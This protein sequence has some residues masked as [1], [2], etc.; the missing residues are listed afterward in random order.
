MKR[1]SR[2]IAVSLTILV[3][4]GVLVVAQRPGV[5]ERGPRG[6]RLA[7]SA[8]GGQSLREL[9][10]RVE[11]MTRVRELRLRAVQ[12]DPVLPG[13]QHERL[14]QYYKGVKVFGGE[15]IRETDGQVTRSMTTSLY[16]GIQLDTNPRLS[17]AD[18]VR[19]FRRETGATDVGALRPELMI[20]P[21]RDGT[22]ALVYRVTAFVETELPVV[23]VN[24][25]NGAVEL[26]YNNLRTQQAT[27]LAGNGVLV[28]QNIGVATDQKKVSVTL[29]GSTYQAWDQM[30]PVPIKT[31]DL[32]GNLTRTKDL[33]AGRT[34]FVAAD[35]AANTSTTG[36]LDP[37]VV[38]GH[39]YM[40][41]TYDYYAKR[42]GWKGYDGGNFR[43]VMAIVHPAYRADFTKYGSS[44]QSI[45][46]MNAFFCGS[47]G[48]NREDIM[49]FG[50]GLPTGYYTVPDGQYL[51]YW[52]A[53]LDVVAH[54]YTHGV[55]SYTS[56]LI[57]LNESGAL[58]EAFSDVMS[59]SVR[60]YLRPAGSGLLYADY[61]QG[62]D[63]ARAS[64]P[65][66]QNGIRNLAD[67]GALGD[68]DH[69][70][71]RYT[72]TADNGGVHTNST[73]AGHAFY[74]AIEGGTNRTSGLSVQGVGATSREQVEKAFFRG[75]TTLPS[76]ATFSQARAKTIQAARD[77]Y[78]AGSNAER[79]ITQAW[80]AVG[81]L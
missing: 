36:W 17:G 15:A 25:Q 75:F 47:C 63:C 33:V 60:F 70:S 12:P 73:I 81:V 7:T 13:R 51:D 20:F 26:R 19:V 27:A 1:T 37:V 71:N 43:A 79:A 44:D 10:G 76:N 62:R 23:F 4:L 54:E 80:T 35:L 66:S 2:L 55:T 56:N 31:Y 78:G 69:Y 14:D 18:A 6:G 38:D 22:Y 3:A 64:R 57:Y 42:I 53:A 34:A 41:W 59:I 48:A 32:K 11:G 30:R 67:P 58:D 61:T 16:S 52:V 49:M 74:L 21:R 24:A 9:D 72:G 5:E 46:Y 65:G 39:T 77:I 45:Y 28:S 40:G 50:E 68:P 29:Q 8:D